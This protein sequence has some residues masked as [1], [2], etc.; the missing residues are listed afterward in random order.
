MVL[1]GS[2]IVLALLATAALLP[3]DRA[4]AWLRAYAGVAIACGV[5]VVVIAVLA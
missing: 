2:G 4:P 1:V 3:T 5:L